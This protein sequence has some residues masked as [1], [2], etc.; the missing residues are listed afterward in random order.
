M[1][2]TRADARR[3]MQQ[4]ATLVSGA[5]AGLDDAAFTSPTELAGWTRAHVVAHLSANADAVGQPRALG[6]HRRADADVLVH[7]AAQRRHRGGQPPV[8]A[9]E[10][11]EW[12]NRSAATLDDA[13]ASLTDQQWEAEVVTAQGRTVPASETPWMRAREVMV[14]AVDLGTGIGFD[15]LPEDFLTA[16]CDDIVGKRTAAAGSDAAGP[17]LA[18][19]ATDTGGSLDDRRARRT[20]SP[21]WAPSAPSPP[22][23]PGAAPMA[24]PLPTAAPPR[25]CPPGSDLCTRRS[26]TMTDQ[27]A[28]PDVL[29]IGGGIGGLSAA[30]ALTAA[31]A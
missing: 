18:I 30:F 4:G 17:A 19:E 25:R 15:D 21:S 11:T 8:L 16:L 23:S 22:T 20:P 13:M 14:H 29:V 28:T 3:W 9:S 7:G 10:L 26:T 27:S 2:R 31:R 12:F 24:S 6:G 1:A 5:L